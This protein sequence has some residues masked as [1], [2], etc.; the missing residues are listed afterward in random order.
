MI[1]QTI[2]AIGSAVYFVFFLLFLG[3]SKVPRT[4]PGV[5]WFAAAIFSAFLSR[6]LY[7]IFGHT[8]SSA[9]GMPIYSMFVLGEKC[10]LMI[11]VSRFYGSPINERWIWLAFGTAECWALTGLSSQ[12]NVDI[13]NLGLCAFNAAF[14][15][16]VSIT[17]L[18][19]NVAI[20][21]YIRLLA[22][23]TSMLLVLHWMLY[24]PIYTWVFPDWRNQAFLLGTS[25]VLLQYFAL[26]TNVFFLFQMRLIESE[27]KALEIA[28][29]DSLTGLNN[30]RYIDILFEKVLMLT[31]RANQKLAI[32]YID[33]DKFKPIN[34]NAGHKV[35]DLVLKE[36]AR[37][38]K[39][40]IRSSDICARVGGDEFVI[41]LTQIEEEN[42]VAEITQKLLQQLKLPIDAAGKQYFLGAS[43]GVSLYP[44][45]GNDL[46]DLIDKADKAMYSVKQSGRHG[47]KQFNEYPTASPSEK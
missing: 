12:P 23:I 28:Y 3:A 46:A 47:Y 32:L 5:S 25:L 11:A 18:K 30:K 21:P 43:I 45:D 29:H 39:D 9:L 19:S 40:N 2:H 7:W 31:N 42:Y 34:D 41:I 35:G 4:N 16:F 14:L 44:Q 15:L 10:F 26:L 36:I 24:V 33:L 20:P 38:L 27:S 17:L 6:I 8:D 13:F 1:F 22:V 37:R